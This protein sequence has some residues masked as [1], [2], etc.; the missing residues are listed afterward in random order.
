MLFSVSGGSLKKAGNAFRRAKAGFYGFLFLPQCAQKRFLGKGAPN[1]FP[2]S[3]F[4]S[5]DFCVIVCV[6]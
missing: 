5:S 1:R 2:V 4:K 3:L 6:L